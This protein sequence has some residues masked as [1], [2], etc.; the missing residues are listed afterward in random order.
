MTEL[1]CAWHEPPPNVDAL[2]AMGMNEEELRSLDIIM[3][4][5]VLSSFVVNDTCFV[6]VDY[7]GGCALD[8]NEV[9]LKLNG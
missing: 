1:V 3:V 7:A 8:V 5:P 9:Q 2:A 4:R 6:V